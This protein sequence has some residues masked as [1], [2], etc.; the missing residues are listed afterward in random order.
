MFVEAR[1][2]ASPPCSLSPFHSV[3]MTTLQ[4]RDGES[5]IQDQET[6]AQRG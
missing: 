5:Y 1:G 6:E 3:H 4:D 2:K